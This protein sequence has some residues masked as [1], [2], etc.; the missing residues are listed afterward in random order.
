[1]EANNC[2]FCT[3]SFSS[4]YVCERCSLILNDS[5]YGPRLLRGHFILKYRGLL[6]ESELKKQTDLYCSTVVNKLYEKKD[7]NGKSIDK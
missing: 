3:T 6:S 7:S 4:C 5:K 2:Q 1:M